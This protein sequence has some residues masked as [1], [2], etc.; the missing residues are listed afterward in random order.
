M[1]IV[2]VAVTMLGAMIACVSSAS[3]SSGW[4]IAGCVTHAAR[5]ADHRIGMSFISRT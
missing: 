1:L 4:R 5:A 3:S 2:V